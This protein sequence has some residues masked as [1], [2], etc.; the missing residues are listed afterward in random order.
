MPFDILVKQNATVDDTLRL[1]VN[2]VD[3]CS[4]SP[5]VQQVVSALHLSNPEEP[6]L[7]RLK[8]LFD[9]LCRNAKYQ[10]D[11]PGTEEVWT[12]EKVIRE[13][14]FDCKKISVF[15]ASVLKAADCGF[16]PI[17][18]HVYYAGPNGSLQDYT[19]IY[20]IVPASGMHDGSG[21]HTMEFVLQP[22]VTMD[23]T[24]DCKFNTEV[25]SSKQTL[26]F[27][28]GQKM[29]LHMMG[30]KP[31]APA[32]VDTSSFTSQV[33][34]AACDLDNQMQAICGPN[35]MSGIGFHNKDGNFDY[36]AA[37]AAVHASAM[38]FPATVVAR[39]AFLGL[40]YLGK[41]LRKTSIKFN[42]PFMIANAWGRDPAGAHKLWWMFGGNGNANMLRDAVTKGAGI[43]GM[44]TLAGPIG[45]S[46][47][48]DYDRP[49]IIT[50]GNMH[51]TVSGTIGQGPETLAAIAAATPII[52]KFLDWIKKTTGGTNDG[53][54]DAQLPDPTLP[55]NG[56]P[57]PP[58][59]IPVQGGSFSTHSIDNISDL[60]NFIKAS[61][62]INLGAS[63]HPALI[64]PS[65]IITGL[66]FIYAIRNKILFA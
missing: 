27:L 66:S 48:P 55:A 3:V 25:A 10:L 63:F 62:I 49:Y 16:D 38:V 14:T 32:P 56:Q 36:S 29:D 43:P 26:Y 64:I 6:K 41:L 23:P 24:N 40:L 60:L 2:A 30:R 42:L 47:E 57:I 54:P 51:H 11:T 46:S 9:Y 4:R 35:D 44:Q 65:A 18:K 17:L 52:V 19:H 53:P 22:Y 8:R 20:V 33:N 1:I 34:N 31:N 39:A 37:E 21:A 45:R 13:G 28:N 7:T 58:G 15:I 12:P 61:A 59:G 50:D 5:F